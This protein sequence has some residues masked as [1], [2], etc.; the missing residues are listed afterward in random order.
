KILNLSHLSEIPAYI[1]ET[2]EGEPRKVGLEMDVL[3]VKMYQAYL[4]LFPNQEMVD[5][6]PLIRELRMVKS[7][8]E[9]GLI[10]KAAEMSDRLYHRIP[11]FIKDSETEND[12][13]L[14]AESFYRSQ[15][16]PGICR[17]R[18]FNLE[19]M[20]G[21]IM[22]GSNAALPSASPGPTG[23]SG[24]GPFHSQGAGWRK[25]RPHE[26]IIV[27]YTASADGYLS[28]QARIF[29]IGNLPERLVRAHQVMIEVQD[30]LAR[31]G[32]PGV[33]AKALYELALGIVDRAGLSKGFMG[34]PQP[35]PFVAHGLGLEL[36]EWPILGRNSDHILEAG[37]V[38]AMEPKVI[39]PGE[40]VVG[41]ENTFVVTEEGMEK[42]N[43]F[44]D[45]IVIIS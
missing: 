12:L 4:R 22:A 28:D 34:H 32:R 33:K 10:R 18:G 1:K 6:S 39:F 21:H 14:K 27:D 31:R 15:G 24:L 26:P 41:I 36:D 20:Y 5:I 30:A 40:G 35:V 8:D 29:S 9:I 42:L 3:P 25:L 11:E 38:I 17:M 45:E 37:M 43:Q 7:P 13:A 2:C 23:G 44:P 19:T 16:H